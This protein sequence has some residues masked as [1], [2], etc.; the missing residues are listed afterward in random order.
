MDLTRWVPGDGVRAVL[1]D[2][3][4]KEGQSPSAQTRLTHQ[5]EADETASSSCR[6]QGNC[7]GAA[8]G[9]DP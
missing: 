7:D 3:E 9:Q 4:V 6:T 1:P 2:G 5:Y 8:H